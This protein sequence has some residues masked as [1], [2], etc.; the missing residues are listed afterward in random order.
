MTEKICQICSQTMVKKRIMSLLLQNMI[1]ENSYAK[2]NRLWKRVSYQLLF[3]DINMQ[4]MD[5]LKTAMR[6]KEKYPKLPVVLVT[7]Y[8]REILVSICGVPTPLWGFCT[9]KS[10]LVL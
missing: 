1:L 7:A 8:M 4:G 10:I 6:I 5:G 2:I 9:M 3:L